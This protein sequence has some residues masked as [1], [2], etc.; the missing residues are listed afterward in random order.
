MIFRISVVSVV[1][2]LPSLLILSPL[3][4]FCVCVSLAKGLPILSFQ[5]VSLSFIH[6]FYS[7]VFLVSIYFH[8][9]LCYFLP[10]TDLGFHLFF[11]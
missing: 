11:F 6:L 10:F 8:S 7:V 4:F 5:R 3:V 9:D 1:K 2:F